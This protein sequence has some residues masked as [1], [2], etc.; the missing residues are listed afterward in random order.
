MK[1]FV[2]VTVQ[3]SMENILA[4]GVREYIE[5]FY[6]A[7]GDDEG[8]DFQFSLVFE[9]ELTIDELVERARLLLADLPELYYVDTVYRFESE[10]DADRFVVWQDGRYQSYTGKLEFMEDK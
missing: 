3:T 8:T 5:E 7:P 10:F 2:K 1:K 9:T 4:E 6:N